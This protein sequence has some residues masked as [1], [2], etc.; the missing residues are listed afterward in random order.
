MST[1][2]NDPF[3]EAGR[4]RGEL[5]FLPLSYAASLPQMQRRW[6]SQRKTTSDQKVCSGCCFTLSTICI[7]WWLYRL[8]F[9]KFKYGCPKEPMF[10]SISIAPLGAFLNTLTQAHN[11]KTETRRSF[12]CIGPGWNGNGKHAVWWA[13]MLPLKKRLLGFLCL[14]CIL[15]TQVKRKEGDWIQCETQKMLML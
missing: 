10:L 7:Q 1:G 15:H 9:T 13:I 11:S 14:C 2:I 4:L 6:P 8:L 12:V 5:P 3:H